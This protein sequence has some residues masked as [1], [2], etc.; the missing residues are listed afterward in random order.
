M[1]KKRSGKSDLRT[2]LL[3]TLDSAC[4]ALPSGE[5]IVTESLL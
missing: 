4:L 3:A 2:R 1:E 5:W